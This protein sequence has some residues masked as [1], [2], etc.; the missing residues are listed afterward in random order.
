MTTSA[1]DFA[2]G[3]PSLGERIGPAWQSLWDSL[4]PDVWVRGPDVANVET[5]RLGLAVST[6]KNL[7]R[8]AAKAGHLEVELRL[9]PQRSRPDRMVQSAWYRRPAG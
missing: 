3:Y 2:H 7:L 5:A 6:I 4:P 9:E 1:P 8:G